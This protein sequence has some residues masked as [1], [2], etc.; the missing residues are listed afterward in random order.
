MVAAVPR[1]CGTL[2]L[3][4]TLGADVLRVVNQILGGGA[5]SRLFGELRERQGLTYGAYSQL[6]CGLWGGD[7]TASMLVDP[8]KLSRA[9]KSFSQEM[10]R[11]GTGDITE[12]EL[13]EAIDYLVGSFPQRA[14]GL[15]GVSSLSMAAWLHSLPENVW[16]DYQADLKRVTVDQAQLLARKWIPTTDLSWV[17]CGSPNALDESRPIL[18]GMGKPVQHVEIASL[19]D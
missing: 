18:E 14:S 3:P 7:L 10:D 1:K 5:A 13:N 11:I 12:T 17:V 16:R 2:T 8:P 4:P 15:A 6:D 9:L 19:V